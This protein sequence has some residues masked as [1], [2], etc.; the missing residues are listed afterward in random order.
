VY[1]RA[2]RFPFH[3]RRAG[4]SLGALQQFTGGLPLSDEQIRA[5]ARYYGMEQQ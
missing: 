2:G 5:Q 4:V 3:G 1:E